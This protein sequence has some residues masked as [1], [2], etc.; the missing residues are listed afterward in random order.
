MMLYLFSKWDEAE[1]VRIRIWGKIT[2]I[3][4][5]NIKMMCLIKGIFSV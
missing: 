3:A 1:A 2:L 5:H 4:L